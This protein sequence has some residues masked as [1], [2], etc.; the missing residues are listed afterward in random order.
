MQDEWLRHVGFYHD[1]DLGRVP[2]T[3][4]K[5]QTLIYPSWTDERFKKAQTVYGR[6]MDGLEYV[7]DDRLVQWDRQAHERGREVANESGAPQ[8]KL[9]LV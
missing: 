2:V 1:A 8:Q 6:K 4:S 7:Y 5:E 9:S 3:F